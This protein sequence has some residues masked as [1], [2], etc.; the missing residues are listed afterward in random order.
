MYNIT[1]QKTLPSISI[2]DAL[3]QLLLDFTHV[4]MSLESQSNR[5][6][7]GQNWMTDCMDNDFDA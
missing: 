6:D 3:D 5:F 7:D 4:D 2:C 1:N